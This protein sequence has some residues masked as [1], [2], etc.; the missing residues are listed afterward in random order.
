MKHEN[1]SC[2][3]KQKRDISQQDVK[4][5]HTRLFCFEAAAGALRTVAAAAARSLQQPVPLHCNQK[6]R[7]KT[8]VSRPQEELTYTEIQGHRAWSSRAGVRSRFVAPLQLHVLPLTRGALFSRG[9]GV[10]LLRL[11][12][13]CI[14]AFKGDNRT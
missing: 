10:L 9:F 1:G 3:R 5:E 14:V 7:T 8:N 11:E 4:A 6:E 2:R 13:L 12:G